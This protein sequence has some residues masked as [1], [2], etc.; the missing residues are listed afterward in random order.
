MSS[1]D[2]LAQEITEFLRE[3]GITRPTEIQELAIP[4]LLN[5]REDLLLIAPTGTGKTEAALLP[6]LHQL[7]RMKQVRG[8]LM[9]FYI[10]Y[11]TPLRALNRDV[12]KRVS[13]LC[14]RLG[15]TVDVRHGDTTRYRRRKQS[16]EPPNVL[17]T[18]PETFQ[19]IL[20]GKRL[21]YHL[22]TVSCVVI[23][24]IHELAGSK[25]GVQLAIGLERL[26]NLVGL[27]VRRVGLSATVGNPRD[28]ASLVGGRRGPARTLWAGQGGPRTRLR[29]EMP[30]PIQRHKRIAKKLSYP[31]HS[32]AR[33]ERITEL[34]CSHRST[35][36]FTNTRSFAEVLG[37]KMRLMNPPFE[38][39]VHHGSLS[40]DVRVAAENRLKRGETKAV[41][42]TS[43]LEL[44]IDIGQADLVIQYSSPREVARAL[45]RT[46]RA[47]HTVG[48][49]GEGV[50]IATA[51]VDDITES[52]V[53]L[54]RARANRVE[55][56]QIAFGAIDVLAHQI[57][58]VVLDVGEIETE[59]LHRVLKG[60]FP[61]GQLSLQRL[62]Q[63]L[64]F[65]AKQHL[66]RVE[67]SI[68]RMGARTRSHY[69]ENLSMIPDVRQI[70]AV[71][72][73]TRTS[74]GVLDEDYVRDN[75]SPG[76][77]FIIRG[78]PY[79]VLNIEEDEILCA[80]ATN[81]QSD[82]PRWIGEMIPVPYEVATEVAD[83]WNRV[84]HRNDREVRHDLAKVY[85][86]DEN[87]IQHL[88]S[89]IRAQYTALGA[90]PSKKRLV[91][92]AFSDGVVI[93][94]P[95]GTK[96][97]E[98]LGIV[99]AALLTTQIGVEVGV[100]R[101]PYRILL[102]STRAIPPENIIRILRGYT[103]GQVREILRLALKTTQTFASRFVHVA[104]RMGIVRRD[105]KISEIPVKRLLAAY[106]ESPVF[107][108]AMREVLQEKMDEARVCEI[109]EGVRR[110][111][112]EVLIA[113]TERPSPLARLIVEERSRFE[114]MGELSEEG[115][116]LR[117]VETR[118]L[119]R[120][121]RLVC[122][123]G[124]WE[125]VRTVSTLEEQ[126]TCPTC[127]STM[128]AAVPVSHAGLR[129]ILRKRREGEILSKHE[130]REYSAAALSAS[131]VS[132]YGKRALLVLAG[133]GIGP[134]TAARILT[135]G[136][137]ENRLELLR[138]ITEAEKTY[139][140]TRRFWD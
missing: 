65:M 120:Q 89:T 128:I 27:R 6:L 135:P 117:L 95:F 17:I 90:L 113:R 54:R 126:V 72:S 103:A 9:G 73:A 123:N 98:T 76:L 122:M 130:M 41:I 48:E 83:V 25:R 62:E 32:V 53:I 137:A 77:V 91:I 21:K 132:Q 85:G 80:P 26:E 11:V 118:L 51:N 36:V 92:E 81:T 134:T 127:G 46:G 16:L 124:D 125:S 13:E 96:V 105:A 49:S 100:E 78:R 75:V 136:A 111:N 33:L 50:I 52:G 44:G 131:L 7:F 61:Y 38:F 40:R 64:V 2:A 109:F 60:A 14:N 87:C 12:F 106:S 97:N 59:K 114:V 4:V 35:I 66:V 22:K 110:E 79:Q 84:V 71:D 82:A 99:I 55:R 74:I 93:H 8:G 102:V 39:D 37:A 88:T 56:T 15:V 18:T 23:D 28:V 112:I 43:S 94:A 115:E 34:I 108:E 19:A 1:F 47:G 10:L 104:R 116:V 42:A 121:F 30:I 29:V 3:H 57:T 58:G 140:Q 86:F 24:E 67:G 31:P 5:S 45:Q 133:R 129:N 20:P 70:N 69:Y 101:D 68:V 63:I 138:R 139:A 119:A 107:E